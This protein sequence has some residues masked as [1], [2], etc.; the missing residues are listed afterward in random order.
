MP[1]KDEGL[2]VPRSA[3]HWEKGRDQPRCTRAGHGPG[4]KVFPL[5]EHRGLQPG[6]QLSPTGQD[7]A[8]ASLWLPAGIASENGLL[9][10]GV[11]LPPSLIKPLGIALDAA[12]LHFT[13]PF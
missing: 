8:P 4:G 11:D 3:K 7:S 6:L 9:W 12:A 5:Q 13:N 2:L 10:K 1:V